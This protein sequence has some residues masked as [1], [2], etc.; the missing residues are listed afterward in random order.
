VHRSYPPPR[1]S[2]A[3]CGAPAFLPK[4]LWDSKANTH[5]ENH[6]HHPFDPNVSLMTR[7]SLAYLLCALVGSSNNQSQWV[8]FLTL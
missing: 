5:T 1:S 2:I 4:Q 7:L 3:K 8:E 6:C